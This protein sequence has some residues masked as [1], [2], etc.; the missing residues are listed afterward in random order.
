[1]EIKTKPYRV[2]FYVV[3]DLCIVVIGAFY[4]IHRWERT[5]CRWDA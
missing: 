4:V 3:K 5:L 1:M 2:K